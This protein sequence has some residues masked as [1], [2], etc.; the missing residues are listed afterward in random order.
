MA[1]LMMMGSSHPIRAL[2][3][4]LNAVC[5]PPSSGATSVSSPTVRSSEG[6]EKRAGG[7]KRPRC[8]AARES[9]SEADGVYGAARSDRTNA[10]D[11]PF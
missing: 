10:A 6:A 1:F 3:A 4:L 9:T 8:T 5:P 7:S 11:G 2:S